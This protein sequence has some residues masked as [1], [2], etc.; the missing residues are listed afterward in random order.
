MYNF[1]VQEIESC[2]KRER[3]PS[4]TYQG[5]VACVNDWLQTMRGNGTFVL[6][7]DGPGSMRKLQSTALAP[8]D[9]TLCACQDADRNVL[10]Q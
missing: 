3:S 6:Y 5:A 2:D 4:E 10:T 7:V 8:L 9:H 1:N